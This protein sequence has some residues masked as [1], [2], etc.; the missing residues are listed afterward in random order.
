GYPRNIDDISSAEIES[1][2]LLKDAA[3][4]ALYG[5]RGANGVLMITSKRGSNDKAKISVDYHFGVNTQFR[6]PKFANAYTYATTLNEALRADG[7]SSRYNEQELLAFKNGTLPFDFPNVNWWKNTLNNRA[8]THNLKFSYSGGNDK[9][10]YFT[11]LDFYRDRSM[12]KENTR[13]SR[14]ST[15]PTDTR[16]SLRSNFDVAITPTTNMKVG[17]LAKLQETN[18]SVIS[19]NTILS[20]IYNTPAAAFPIRY[21]NNIYGGSSVYGD[22][23][24]VALLKDKGHRRSMYGSL[25]ADLS[26]SQKLDVI[27]EGLSAEV[28]VAFDNIGGM[29]EY[30]SKQYRY[31]NSYASLSDQGNLITTPIIYGRDSKEL[32]HSQPFERLLMRNDIQTKIAYDRAFDKHQVSGAVVYDVQSTIQQGRNNT[33]KNQSLLFNASYIYDNRYILNGVINY[34]GSAYLPKNHKFK[35]YPALSA[36]WVISNEEFMKNLTFID[37][38]KLRASYGISGWDGNLTHELW[39]ESYGGGNH[40]FFGENATIEWGGSEGSLPVEGLTAEKSRKA[41]LGLDFS[42]FK[43]RLSASLDGFYEKRSD[44]LVSGSNSTSGIIGIGVGMQN[45][46]EYEYKGLDASINW[47]DKINDFS[48]GIGGSFSYLT[49]KV[50]NEN[51]AF[52]EY[53]YLY[54]KG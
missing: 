11:H 13:D 49:T 21:S 50:I 52:Q 41:T 7:L 3:A 44:V 47:N 28:S 40:Y 26:L 2:Y 48:Y 51:Q 14:Y 18:G 37:F 42:L 46:G 10:K 8:Y 29:Q 17:L 32:G 16:L 23:N 34:S 15:R 4:T 45:A 6:A 53:D 30:S 20:S 9:F 43:N 12:F 35:T 33:I 1:V 5:I 27:T 38:L 19:Q 24:P 36:A 22:R 54:H 25:I 31:M 39:R